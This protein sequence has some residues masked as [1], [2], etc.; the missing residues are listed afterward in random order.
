MTP[1]MNARQVKALMQRFLFTAVLAP[2]GGYFRRV[3]GHTDTLQ[4]Y[5]LDRYIDSVDAIG[6]VILEGICPVCGNH[7]TF[8][9]FTENLRESGACSSCGSSNRQRQMAL[10]VRRR[11]NLSP[12]GPMRFPKNFSIY[13]AEANGVLHR[14]LM[15][16]S[17]YVCSEYFGSTYS[18]GKIIKGIRHEDLQ[19]LSFK[20][21]SFDLSLS[22]DVLEHMPAPYDAHR[23]IF[24]VLKRGGR[25]IFTV[26]F[27]PLAVEDDV[28]AIIEDGEI[29]YLS[30]KLYHGDPVRPGDGILVWTIF[31]V[32]MMRKLETIGFQVRAWNLYEPENG[33]VGNCNTIFE[34]QKPT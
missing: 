27:N 16:N 3:T 22:S 11:F 18:S 28:R 15:L 23:E 25:H 32:E 5:P 1:H 19:R 31:G 9:R 2:V 10:M 29:K 4:L 12:I 26:P 7:A 17:G 21:E 33:I 8:T 6:S 34:A 24:R 14:Q 30:E 13:N 20:N